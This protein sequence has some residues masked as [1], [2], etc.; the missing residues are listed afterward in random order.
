MIDTSGE[1]TQAEAGLPPDELRTSGPA[2]TRAAAAV[3]VDVYH[4]RVAGAATGIPA[5]TP[6]T[7]EAAVYT[8]I[9]DTSW[10][11]TDDA[12]GHM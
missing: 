3:A 11:R 6:D 10:L 9:P 12:A 4:D 7:K 1:V 8:G 5:L 2:A